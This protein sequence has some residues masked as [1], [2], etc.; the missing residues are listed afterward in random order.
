MSEAGAPV[1]ATPAAGMWIT[2]VPMEDAVGLNIVLGIDIQGGPG[3]RIV[4]A[5]LGYGHE[6]EEGVFYLLPDDLLAR[7]ERVG[8]R[9]SVR[10]L[11][12]PT[13]IERTLRSR[14]DELAATAAGLPPTRSGTAASRCC[15]A[16]SGPTPTSSSVSVSRTCRRS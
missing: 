12:W 14:D 3:E 7:C 1:G 10:L 11:A 9:V 2:T 8:D 16:R 5:L 4:S 13:V 15:A 6:G